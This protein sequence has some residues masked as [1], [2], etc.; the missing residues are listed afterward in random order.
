MQ[1][2]CKILI[3][4]NFMLNRRLIRVK[5]FKMLF[6]KIST[7]VDS[8]QIVE[9]ELISSCEKAV[10][11][12]C[13]MLSLPVF[14][15]K[16]AEDKI[17]NGLK[18]FH[19]TAE[20]ANPNRRFIQNKFIE[21]IEDDS[22]FMNYCSSKGISW[23]ENEL[24]V[25]K[26]L[27]K[28]SSEEYYKEYMNSAERSIEKDFELFKTIFI[29]EFE[30]NEDLEEILEDKSLFWIDDLAYVI[31]VILKNMSVIERKNKISIPNAFMK[32]EDREYALKLLTLSLV[33]YEEYAA[34]VS[35]NVPN[36]DLERL[37]A[38]DLALIVMGI[39]EAV[40]FDSIPLK[41]TINEYVDISKFFST[42]NSK[43]FVNGLLD[44]ILQKMKSEG[45]ILKSG[46][47]LIEESTQSQ[48]LN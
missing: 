13:L 18:K 9:K 14:L 19:P 42:T 15:K 17:E 36:W 12:Y 10:D 8:V 46:R 16:V 35:K 41:V 48:K 38:T 31:N 3:K 47:G 33:N 34:L 6:S 1:Y 4:N 27:A 45:K 28:I 20:E 40:S 5:V 32:D 2:I 25:K 26:L 43:M 44:K 7:G 11:L 21:V 39:T 24:F 23:S 30:D 37:V 22:K 29:E